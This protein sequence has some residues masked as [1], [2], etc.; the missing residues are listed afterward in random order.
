[1]SERKFKYVGTRP[2]RHDGF[3]KVTGRAQF[4]ADQN[5]PGM[6]QGAIL[7]SPHAH[8]HIRSIDTRKAPALEGVKGFAQMFPRDFCS[9]IGCRD[10]L[11]HVRE[12]SLTLPQ[13]KEAMCELNLHFVGFDSLPT[14]V[15]N[16]FR[17][18]H[19]D[20]SV[21]SMD[22]W[23]AFDE[24]HPNTLTWYLFWCYHVPPPPPSQ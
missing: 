3:D 22:E 23:H 24:S 6:L 9:T 1:M 10:L 16:A 8:A 15:T 2:I 4:G 7:R 14:S 17:Q 21:C 19:G 5:L 13:L 18:E 11:M 20:Q 12:C